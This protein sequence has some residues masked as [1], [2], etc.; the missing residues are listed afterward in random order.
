MKL[1]RKVV[2]EKYKREIEAM[3]AEAAETV[4][5]AP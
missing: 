3:Y 4:A 2:N 5:T 1:K